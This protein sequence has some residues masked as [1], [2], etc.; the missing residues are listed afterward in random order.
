MLTSSQ[1]AALRAAILADPV[2]AAIPQTPDGAFSVAEAFNLVAAPDFWVWRTAV[3]RSDIYNSVSAD[4]TNWNWTTY[5]NQGVAEQNAW[6]QMF[7]GD[8][9]NFAQDN[10]RAGVEAI[11]A[12]SAQATLQKNHCLAVGRR[13]ASRAEKLFAVGPGSTG[14]PAKMTFEGSLAYQDVLNAWAT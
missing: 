10:V 2:L 7:M 5:K 12:G 1:L 3:S 4:A 8:Q 6:T 11:F 14:T 13:K 9:A